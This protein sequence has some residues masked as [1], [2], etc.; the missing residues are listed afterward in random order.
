MAARS[1]GT[2]EVVDTLVVGLDVVV[3]DKPA[4]ASDPVE[5]L[6]PASRSVLT[7]SA[8]AAPVTVRAVPM[9]ERYRPRRTLRRERCSVTVR[10]V[11]S[12]TETTSAPGRPRDGR[13]DDAI[14]AA[15]LE[16][17]DERG[18]TGLTLAAV[19]ERAGTT[20]PAIYRR[21]SSKSDLV[22]AAAFRTGGDDVVAATGDLETDVRTMVRWSLEKFASPAGRAA[23]VG[24]LAEPAG[25]G[26]N[27]SDE[28]SAV[29]RRTAERLALAAES[30]EVRADVDAHLLMTLLSGPALMATAVF[31]AGADDDEWVDRIAKVILD[32]VQPTG[33]KGKG[34]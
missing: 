25:A 22:M 33:T 31:G 17:L 2:V 9:C 30:G 34:N 21:W 11:M 27:R 20:T 29:W 5:P 14:V 13:L 3:V 10:I 28:L 4:A 16:L 6:Q 12:A 8:A 19:A 23:L 7:A 32:G 1:C 24:L 18:Y 15:T 26:R